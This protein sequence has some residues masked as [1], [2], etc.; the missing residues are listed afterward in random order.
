MPD[1]SNMTQITQSKKGI[2]SDIGSG[3]V[4]VSKG[5]INTVRNV[6]KPTLDYLLD[7]KDTIDL[8]YPKNGPGKPIISF[9][10]N[11]LM[12]PTTGPHLMIQGAK[13]IAKKLGTVIVDTEK[14]GASAFTS[15]SSYI[16]GKTKNIDFSVAKT[17]PI[18]PVFDLMGKVFSTLLY[19]IRMI[20]K[21]ANSAG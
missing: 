15:I 18:K 9:I 2:I 4:N 11:S 17:N 16:S 6:G 14:V 10:E 3:I 21:F 12:I 19:P 5:I 8:G 20:G 1:K 13:Y 7:N